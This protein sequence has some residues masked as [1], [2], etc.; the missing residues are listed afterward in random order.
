MHDAPRGA[1]RPALGFVG[2][3]SMGGAMCRNLHG[4]TGATVLIHDK[5]PLA[6]QAC[7]VGD[8]VL[9]AGLGELA[10]TCD[11]IFLALPGAS[12]VGSVCL[13]EDGL[14]RQMRQGGVVVDC[15]T[16]TQAASHEMAARFA[17]RDI[18]YV[19]AP[20]A[21]TVETVAERKIT[22][23]VGADELVFAKL[24]PLF[25][26]MA[27]EVQYCGSGG[28]GIATKLL[29]NMVI[30]Q[31]VIAL[32]EALT[33]GRRVGLDGARLFEAFR[34]GCDS[35]ALR[36]HGLTALLPGCFPEGRFSTC[37][38]LKDL[39]YVLQMA[40]NQGATLDGT[41]HARDLLQRTADAGH[42]DAYWPALIKIIEQDGSRG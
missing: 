20:V 39:D 11:T 29:L 30:A 14:L 18:V 6:A 5:N 9:A 38:M 33:L 42:G 12:E 26:C 3:G 32:A 40:Q 15:S 23:M 25:A 17:T 28:N 41:A 24:A 31:S 22:I 16:V 4:G 34:S 13:G 27:E 37:Y 7:L 2:L 35:F 10:R 19:D 21:G 36:H 1:V 8:M